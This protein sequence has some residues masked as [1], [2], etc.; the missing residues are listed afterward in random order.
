MKIRALSALLV[1]V[2][3]AAT[4]PIANSQSSTSAQ[5][6][7]NTT[8][9]DWQRL[10]DLKSGKE[11]LVEF[12]PNTSDS[13]EGKFVSTIGDKL[14]VIHHGDTLR[15]EQRDIQ[16]VYRLKGRWSRSMAM[17]VGAVIGAFAGGL[18]GAGLAIRA[19]QGPDYVPTDANIGPVVLGLLVGGLAGAGVGRLTLGKR[20]GVLLY[21]A[22]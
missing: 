7:T 10:S 17:R 13:F 9:A 5:Q 15:L 14:I 3:F 12:K 21:E 1:F 6:S 4:A 19:E 11:I 8:S 22:K 16:S 18:I 2:L 20:R